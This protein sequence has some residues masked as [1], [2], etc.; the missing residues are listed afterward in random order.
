MNRFF[1]SE[2]W[3]WKPFSYV[4][5][6]FMLSCLWFL[7]SAPLITLGAATT[8]LYDVTARCVRG[9]EKAMFSRFFH[10]FKKEFLTSA[11]SSLLWAAI[12]GVCY[13]CVKAYGNSVAP[14]D[15]AVVIT[16]AALILLVVI[17]GIG[18]WVFPLLSR[19]TFGFAGLNVTAVKLAV[20]QLPRTML[21]GV[22]TVFAAYLCLQFWVP[23]LFL[24][25]LLVLLWSVLIEPVFQTYM[26]T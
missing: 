24:P 20:S 11:L 25:G 19:F 23:F 12:I 7:C 8:A 9:G 22:L 16:V 4:A 18:C 13:L 21:M 5:D 26:K 15:G 6:I 10:T 1:N 17:V 2:S 14:T 3:L